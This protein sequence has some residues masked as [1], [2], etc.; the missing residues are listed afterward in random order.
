MIIFRRDIQYMYR[1][2]RLIHVVVVSYMDGW[3][4]LFVG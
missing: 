1:T 3:M 4:D 2:D